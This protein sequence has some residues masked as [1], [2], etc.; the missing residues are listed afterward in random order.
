MK[1]LDWSLFSEE[2]DKFRNI[3]GRGHNYREVYEPLLKNSMSILEIGVWTGGFAAFCKEQL[4]DCFYVGVDITDVRFKPSLVDRADE[5]LLL[6]AYSL[7]FI[8]YIQDEY[9]AKF[10]LVIDDG[11]HTPWSQLWIASQAHRLVSDTGTFVCEDV[12]TEEHAEA[13]A[14]QMSEQFSNVTIWR[15]DFNLSRDERCVIGKL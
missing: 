7:E 10:D 9:G 2:T 1:T 3:P 14:L 4:E 5:I 11:P 13:I 15:G 6:N 12:L 8:D